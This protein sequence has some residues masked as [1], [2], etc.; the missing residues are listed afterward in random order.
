[1]GNEVPTPGLLSTVMCFSMGINDIL[2]NLC[3]EPCPAGLAADCAVGEEAFEDLPGHPLAG[4]DGR[5]EDAAS[6]LLCAATHGDRPA[7][8]NLGIALFTSL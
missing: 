5:Q 2:D 1:M 7:R 8:R 3:A 6:R 4:V